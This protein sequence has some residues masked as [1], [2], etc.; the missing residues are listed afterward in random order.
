MISDLAVIF[1]F[2]FDVVNIDLDVLS[3]WRKTI[4]FF[5]VASIAVTDMHVLGRYPSDLESTHVALA[6]QVTLAN[7][8]AL[9]QVALTHV[10]LAWGHIALANSVALAGVGSARTVWLLGG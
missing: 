3:V 1:F 2:F 5:T 10:T 6:D 8:V 4:C 9:A 7:H